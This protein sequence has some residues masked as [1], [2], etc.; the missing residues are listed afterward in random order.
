MTVA[1]L[2]P[3]LPLDH[4]V[5]L[6]DDRG[7]FEHALHGSPRPEHGYCTDD[8]AR[9]LTA[10]L[11]EPVRTPELDQLAGVYLDFVEH[12]VTVA[13][14]VHNRMSPSGQ[15]L[16]RPGLGD[17]WGRAIGGLGSAVRFAPDP[18]LRYRASRVF[19]RAAGRRS[20]EVR[21][22][23]FAALGAA[24]A[25]VMSPRSEV[26]RR[27]LLDCVRV[28]PSITVPDVPA[29]GSS[30]GWGWPEARL[31]YANASLCSAVLAAGEA[32]HDNTLVTRGLTMLDALLRIETNPAGHLSVTGSRGRG[33]DDSSPLWDQQPIEVAAI[34]DAAR[35]A[36]DLTGDSRWAD[37]VELAWQWFL[38]VNDSRQPMVD[39][40]TGAGFDGLELGGRNENCGA[41]STLAALSTAQCVR[42]V[43]R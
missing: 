17:W 43:G 31:R 22:S 29:T 15:W 1:T 36:F 13:G 18:Q 35:R 7:L 4:L 34:A 39:L 2:T 28:I 16:D 19:L 25:L 21:S 9:A 24:D 38:G 41:E 26:A 27:L 8:V 14:A 10:V 20:P 32:L 6:S 11:Q 12:A 5:A 23:A 33:P 3:L 30:A 37:T 40:E 42:A